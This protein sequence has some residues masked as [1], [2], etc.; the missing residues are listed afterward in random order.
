MEVC[1]NAICILGA[2][3]N[4]TQIETIATRK[5]RGYSCIPLWAQ[6]TSAHFRIAIPSSSCTL[7]TCCMAREVGRTL[8]SARVLV[9]HE[10]IHFPL[11]GKFKLSHFHLLCAAAGILVLI[12]ISHQQRHHHHQQSH[13]LCPSSLFWPRRTWFWL[14]GCSSVEGFYY[15]S[16][17]SL[18][19]AEFAKINTRATYFLSMYTATTTMMTTTC[20]VLPYQS[21]GILRT[22]SV[23]HPLLPKTH[24]QRG[25]V[26]HDRP[27]GRRRRRR[28]RPRGTKAKGPSGCI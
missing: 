12:F 19:L 3:W 10:R 8:E 24:N 18:S 1:Q 22:E 27:T 23:L 28:T 20:Y 4:G 9:P 6:H 21:K 11:C 14:S 16:S 26:Y 15:I 17:S 7:V 5:I 13:E 2:H 25:G